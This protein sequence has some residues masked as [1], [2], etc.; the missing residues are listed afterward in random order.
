M[1]FFAVLAAVALLMRQ[2]TAQTPLA[3]LERLDPKAVAEIRTG[4]VIQLK[5]DRRD[6]RE[7]QRDIATD[8]KDLREDRRDLRQDLR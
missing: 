2:R 4:D 5:E 6:I 7:D 8:H 1:V 3:P